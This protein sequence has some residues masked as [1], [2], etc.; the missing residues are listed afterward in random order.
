MNTTR[1]KLQFARSNSGSSARHKYF[2]SSAMESIWSQD[3]VEKLIAAVHSRKY[4]R[5]RRR[6]DPVSAYGAGIDDAF[7]KALKAFS[8][9][10]LRGAVLGSQTL[11][12]EATLLAYGAKH[13]DTIEYGEIVS[14]H[15][16]ISTL[17][18]TEAYAKF[19]NKTHV[20]YDFI[21]SFSS[22]ELSGMGRYGDPMNPVAD[23][24]AVAAMSCLVKKGGRMFLGVPDTSRVHE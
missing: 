3:R 1:K 9:L 15:P 17:R 20:P 8:G 22:V 5:P 16:K 14:R 2:G 11:R 18:P 6:D 10:G 12:L 4:K 21:A 7:D 24:E 13:V 23:I 19:L